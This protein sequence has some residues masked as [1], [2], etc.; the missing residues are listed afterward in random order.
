M[1]PNLL[2]N[3]GHLL[4]LGD[5]YFKDL[6]IAP[7][8]DAQG[9]LQ[10]HAMVIPTAMQKLF[11]CLFQHLSLHLWADLGPSAEP[12]QFLESPP[13]QLFPFFEHFLPD[14]WVVDQPEQ[15]FGGA[16][17]NLV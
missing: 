13:L 3:I 6:S 8:L 9:D 7:A 12:H 1:G 4:Q 17:K 14:L 2:L 5:I 15:P 10:E 16:V 11:C